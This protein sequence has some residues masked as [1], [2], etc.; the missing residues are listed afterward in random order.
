M[1]VGVCLPASARPSEFWHSKV[2]LSRLFCCLPVAVSV[3]FTQLQGI[4]IIGFIAAVTVAFHDNCGIRMFVFTDT[5][6]ILVLLMPQR[7]ATFGILKKCVFCPISLTFTV[8]INITDYFRSQTA[9][10][11]YTWQSLSCCHNCFSLA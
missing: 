2:N 7:P 8:G 6:T 5:F 4:A 11:A 10:S 9:Y 3:S 1:L